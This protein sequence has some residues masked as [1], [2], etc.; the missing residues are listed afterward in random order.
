MI[1]D[2]LKNSLK[3]LE[4]ISYFSI[5]DLKSLYSRTV[6]GPWW[7]TISLSVLL[8]LLSIIWSRVVQEDLNTYLPH[9]VS[10]LIVWR[11][12]S[13]LV[14][15]GC[16]VFLNSIELVKSF[17]VNYSI[18]AA[19]KVYDKCLVFLHHLPIIIFFN[20]YFNVDFFN[21]S[22][23][24]LFYSVPIFLITSYSVCIILGFL[25]TRF[26]D[27][28]PFISMTMSVMMFFTP[29]LW[30]AETIGPKAM[31]FVVQP[32]IFY[33]Y[34]EIIRKPLTGQSPE[35]LSIIITAIFTIFSFV[36]SQYVIKRYSSRIPFWL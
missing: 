33:H 20:F 28:Q 15:Q 4:T 12:I 3:N 19:I 35:T 10:S 24:L 21:K 29:I 14:S 2:D 9:L 23:L 30:K 27:L 32:N 36:L 17:K 5:S 31:F 34:I 25:N 16:M 13:I 1:S 11:F 22:F 26:R 8:V 7:E 6:M 18:L